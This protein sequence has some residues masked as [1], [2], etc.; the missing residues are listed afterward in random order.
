MDARS[1]DGIL[2]GNQT[3]HRQDIHIA[4]PNYRGIRNRTHKFVDN[5]NDVPELYDLMND[6]GERH[7]VADE[8]P[9][10]VADM[11]EGLKY[12]LLPDGRDTG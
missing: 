12:Y 4:M 2:R 5:V 9:D 6:P 3:E 11:R 7:N 1:F 8:C 10:Q